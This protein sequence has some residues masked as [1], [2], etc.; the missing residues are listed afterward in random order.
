MGKFFQVSRNGYSTIG[1]E[2]LCDEIRAGDRLEL[3][4]N[5][6]LLTTAVAE[7]HYY[8]KILDVANKGLKC[9]LEVYP[10][11]HIVLKFGFARHYKCNTMRQ[12]DLLTDKQRDVLG[13]IAISLDE[14]HDQTIVDSLVKLGLVEEYEVISLDGNVKNRYEM[15][16]WAHIAWCQWCSENY[17]D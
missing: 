4:K 6:E 2:V 16:L 17:S 14:G 7:I 15:P 10:S 8:S 11:S 5:G 3:R 1:G 9:G 13:Y 12:F